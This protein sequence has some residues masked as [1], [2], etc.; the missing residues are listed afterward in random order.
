MN[1][2]FLSTSFL[3]FYAKPHAASKPCIDDSSSREARCPPTYREAQDLYNL[4]T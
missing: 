4:L 2:K 3:P 1:L